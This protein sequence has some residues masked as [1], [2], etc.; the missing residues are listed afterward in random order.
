MKCEKTFSTPEF[1][2]LKSIDNSY[3]KKRLKG[4][5]NHQINVNRINKDEPRPKIIGNKT[6]F[7]EKRNNHSNKKNELESRNLS[8]LLVKF[9]DLYLLLYKKKFNTFDFNNNKTKE[10]NNLKNNISTNNK[11]LNID[12]EKKISK[13]NLLNINRIEF[14]LTLVERNMK[15]KEKENILK[16]PK[17]DNL[18]YLQTSNG[19]K[20]MKTTLFFPTRNNNNNKEKLKCSQSFYKNLIGKYPKIQY[21]NK[22]LNNTKINNVV[23]LP[24][25]S[26]MRKTNEIKVNEYQNKSKKNE[27]KI[28]MKK[29][30][31]NNEMVNQNNLRNSPLIIKNNAY[32]TIVIRKRNENIRIIN[33][34]SH[35]SN[36]NNDDLIFVNTIKKS[37]NINRSKMNIYRKDMNLCSF[38]ELPPMNYYKED[39]YYYNIYPSNCGWLIKD[40]LKNRIKWKECHSKNTNLYNFKWKEVFSNN[41]FFDLSLNK[42]QIINHFEFIS[43]LSNK[44]KMFYNFSKY[45]EE[46]N[47]DV[48][49]YLP[50]TIIL[51]LT[52]YEQ[53]LIN[54]DNFKKIF[55]NI[56]DYIFDS[57]SINNKIFDRKKISYK[58][59]FTLKDIKIGNKIYCEIPKSHYTGKNVWIVKAPNLNRGRC[60]KVFNSYRDMI[61]YIKKITEGKVEEYDFDEYKNDNNNINIRI[62][63]KKQENIISEAMNENEGIQEEKEYRYQSSIIII[64]KYIERPYLYK[65]RKCDIRIWVLITHKMEA[66]IFK[67]GHLKASSV[68]YD[69][70]NFDSFVH[71]TNYSLQKYNKNFSKFEKGNEISFKNFQDFIN[72]KEDSFNFREIIFPKFIEIVKNTVLCAKNKINLKNRKY[73]FEILGYD[74]MMDEDKNVYLI[75]I[76]T[77]PGLEISSDLIGELVPRMID[78]ALL[79]TVDDLFPTEYS[80]ENKNEKGEYKSKYHVNGYNDEENMWQFVCDMKKNIDKGMSNSLSYNYKNSK[81]I[82]Q[83]IKIKK[84]KNKK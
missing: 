28:I 65:G 74:F 59:L 51:D 22:I 3:S 46:R 66:Y 36:S 21:E 45:C 62:K 53:F 10:K 33:N 30:N 5:L 60:V 16:K 81:K 57:N 67:E 50:F 49:K 55:N 76:N 4:K 64:Q 61:S 2:T 14:P 71:L 73:C 23:D 54:K 47:I 17:I 48:F 63:N 79:L 44:Y 56:N 25:I 42:T 68:N 6:L 70:D 24:T 9:N 32:D 12:E 84:I 31:D 8:P 40:C 29:S 7:Y 27:E 41:D 77:N 52:N 13:F 83:R 20:T 37:F 18:L 82:K 15:I 38:Y 78:N 43:C 11:N 34:Y 72:G 39:F 69:I 58:T 80:N 1:R 75:E 19:T 35:I 26:T